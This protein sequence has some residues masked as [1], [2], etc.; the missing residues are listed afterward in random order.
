MSWLSI[1]MYE[2]MSKFYFSGY[3]IP[4]CALKLHALWYD[5]A[6]YEAKTRNVCIQDRNANSLYYFAGM[7][8][9]L[10]QIY[11]N[12]QNKRKLDRRSEFQSVCR[13]FEL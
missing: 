11:V 6:A 13:A 3:C 8:T 10:S 4:F 7:K 5:K 9:A 1:K 12:L 2:I